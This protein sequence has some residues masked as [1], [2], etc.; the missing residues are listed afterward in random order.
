MSRVTYFPRYTTAEN[1]VTNTTLHLFSQINQHS[2][3]TFRAVLSELLGDVEMPLGINF[4]QQT[5]STTSVP[6]GSI[7]QEPVHIILET[8]VNAG[9]NVDQ[10]T[11]HCESFD[12]RRKG[13]FLVLLTKETVDDKILDPIRKKARGI[14]IAF[15]NVT[16]EK[17]CNVLKD[18]AKEHETHL[19]S[20]IEDYVAYCNDMNLLPDRR[21][22]LRIVPCGDTFKLN[23]KWNLY[24]QPTERGYSAHEYLGIYHGKA[25][26]LIG[27]IAAIYDNKTDSKGKMQL[28]LVSDSGRD[29]HEFQERIKGMVEDSLKH[30][31]WEVKTD[32][33]FFC[34]EQFQPTEF[35]KS[36]PGG[37]QGPRFWDISEYLVNNQSDADLAKLLNSKVWG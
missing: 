21:K 2:T 9:V 11:R 19:L 10:L 17:L 37:I 1:V 34:V 29:R 22:W 26:R 13:N 36:T 5:R 4:Q 3:D 25:V 6:D 7:Y 12:K 28:Q 32:Y 14:G 15:L 24:Y 18:V 23:E 8:K 20:V 33:R 27:K 30:I 31:G 16:F 35:Q